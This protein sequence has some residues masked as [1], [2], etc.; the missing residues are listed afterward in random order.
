MADDFEQAARTLE[1]L[2]QAISEPFTPAE[3]MEL[4]HAGITLIA[5]RT[6]KGLDADHHSFVAY[7][8]AYAHERE[9]AGYSTKPD[10]VRTGHMVGAMVPVAEAGG[11]TIRFV[12][13]LE[14]TKAAVHNDGSKSVVPVKSRARTG[15]GSG[16]GGNAHR[17]SV[18]SKA[19]RLAAE[20]KTNERRNNTPARPWFDIRHPADV[21][22]IST[23]IGRQIDIRVEKKL[24]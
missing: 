20:G 17:S 22:F 24:K 13:P 19:A 2:G 6:K 4:G 12:N 7:H 8:P 3:A 18:P 1:S 14:A 9:K 16:A 23:A 10:L 11:V 21:D 5:L 15:V